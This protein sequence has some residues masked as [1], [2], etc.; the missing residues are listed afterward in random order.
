M[1]GVV[2]LAKL[3]KCGTRTVRI[4]YKCCIKK[5]FKKLSEAME[6]ED[7]EEMKS[8]QSEV[9]IQQTSL[10]IQEEGKKRKGGGRPRITDSLMLISIICCLIPITDSQGCTSNPTLT[11]N[12]NTCTYSGSNIACTLQFN[13]QVTLRTPGDKACYTF[14]SDQG[15][16]VAAMNLTYIAQQVSVIPKFEYY[17]T[18]WV[19]QIANVK[20]CYTP[21]NWCGSACN[22][23]AATDATGHGQ[24]SD[25]TIT[26]CPGFTHCTRVGGCAGN[27]CFYCEDACSV[28][29]YVAKP[30]GPVYEVY[31]VGGYNNNFLIDVDFIKYDGSIFDGLSHEII[32]V[33]YNEQASDSTNMFRLSLIG[34]F[35]PKISNNIDSYAYASPSNGNAL[36]GMMSFG[37]ATLFGNFA[38]RLSPTVGLLGDIQGNSPTS[39]LCNALTLGSTSLDPNIGIVNS[40]NSVTFK[41]SG[42]TNAKALPSIINGNIWYAD[43]SELIIVTNT[44]NASPI[45]LQIY[46]SG[47][48]SLTRTVTTICPLIEYINTTGCYNCDLGYRIWFNLKSTCLEGPVYITSNDCVDQMFTATDTFQLFYLTCSSTTQGITSLVIAKSGLKQSN[49]TANALLEYVSPDVAIDYYT[50]T[51]VTPTT[52]TL[53]LS[54]VSSLAS[55]FLGNG[56]FGFPNIFSDWIN[57]IINVLLWIVVLFLAFWIVK[58]LCKN[59]PKI[60]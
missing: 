4:F 52:D 54:D 22:T 51:S 25:P 5:P 21:S 34:G 23:M 18:D 57:I 19:G 7:R 8:S 3:C 50:N 11:S 33:D 49:F 9:E 56:I 58:N 1:I 39:F 29:R 43:T 47:S 12:I 15:D 55:N 40:P 59:K 20:S 2:L 10:L 24:F 13:M 45:N 48:L 60:E 35:I 44:S 27:G 31:S 53:S 42:I 30:L 41:P 36:S 38:P 16:I 32:S 6:S 26:Q 46:S 37:A 28:S 17:T 14:V